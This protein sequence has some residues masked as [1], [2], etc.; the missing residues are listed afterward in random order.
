MEDTQA[1]TA[2]RNTLPPSDAAK[3]ETP[4]TANGNGNGKRRKLLIGITLLFV[5]AGAG[6]W[7][8]HH[9][10]GQFQ[11]Y[12]DDAYVQGNLVQLTPRVTGTVVAINA[13]NTDL[14]KQGQTL[15]VLDDTDAKIAL[16]KAE[17]AL[18]E[19][20]RKVQQ[21]YDNEG[22]LKANVAVKQADLAKAEDDYHRRAKARN[23]SVSAE[24]ISHAKTAVDAARAAVTLAQQRLKAGQALIANTSVD[25]HPM[26]LQAEAKV[27]DAYLAL[28]R[29]KI[30]A[31]VTGYVAKRSVQLGSRVSPGTPLLAIVPLHDL[32]ID[33]NFKEAQLEH[34]RIGQPV[35]LTADFYGGSVQ[36]D[37]KV[38]GLA[39]GTGSVF[40]LLPP[41]NATGNWVKIVQRLPVRVS[42][43]PNE[44]DKHP[45]RL[46]LS[47]RVTINTH[48]RNGP[49]LA[50]AP[51]DT[52]VYTTPV[53]D[54][55]MTEADALVARIVQENL[56]ASAPHR[57]TGSPQ[58]AISQ[59]RHPV[60]NNG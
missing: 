7:L 46:G 47:V 24:E 26:V 30:V 33:A 48:D 37:G 57:L 29:T 58:S 31:P 28:K 20:V 45:L 36:Y 54:S 50:Q 15:V 56:G 59:S 12:T 18:G 35:T 55:E 43:D 11:E 13:D 23:G 25:T 52:T 4:A 19:T 34:V 6:Y 32:W 3:T 10:I 49:V 14:V 27:R 44:L 60:R 1:S 17:A 53:Y 40:S 8:Y 2:D 22:Q 21:L 16:Q 39:P 9:F 38:V 5:I 41:Q 51:T 42:I